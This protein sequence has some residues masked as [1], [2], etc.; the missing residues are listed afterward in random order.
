LFPSDTGNR[1]GLKQGLEATYRQM[2]AVNGVAKECM[3]QV[4][5]E[6]AMA[7]FGGYGGKQVKSAVL[8]EEAQG[9]ADHPVHP[10]G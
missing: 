10:N 1:K 3:P 8:F 9:V 4:H 6:M 2:R 5:F 7:A